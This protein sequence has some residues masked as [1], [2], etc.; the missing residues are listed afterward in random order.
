[1]ANKRT[2]SREDRELVRQ[3]QEALP[4]MVAEME[5]L[6]DNIRK[7]GQTPDNA[8]GGT[9]SPRKRKPAPKP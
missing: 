5:R 2:W 8:K 9:P 3:M 1:M 7:S 6:V 4:D